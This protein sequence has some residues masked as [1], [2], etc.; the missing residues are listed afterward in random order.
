M[1]SS[2]P[3]NR[4]VRLLERG[5]VAIRNSRF[6]SVSIRSTGSY[7]PA[8]ILTNEEIVG[9]LPTSP[10]WIVQTLG[11]RQRRI[12][13][14]EEYTSDLAA[15]AGLSAIASAGLDPNEI[16]LVIVATSTPDRTVPSSACMAQNKMGIRNGCPA[17]DVAA[18]CSGF[19]YSITIAGQ[20]IQ[21]GVY[22]RALVIGADTYSKVTNWND[23][24]CV[25]FGDGSGAVVLERVDRVNGM[26][27]SILFADG[28][29]MDDFTVLP[30]D[31]YF[32]MNGRAVYEK[33]T[34][35]LP[36]CIRQILCLNSLGLEDVS[37]IIPHQ[38][39]A[40]VLRRTAEILNIP[41][42]RMQTNL[43]FYANT[44]GATIPLL[45]D[46]A[47]RGGLIHKNDLL[48]FAAIGAG[49]TWA[50]TLYRW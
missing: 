48:L 23:R 40:H 21:N 47:N 7:V 45:L 42:S 46:Q 31:G 36:E 17:L 1:R 6:D 29:G 22:D 4:V 44:A 35:A 5:T 9:N 26:F 37:M 3:E 10:E 19:L 41:Y 39:S 27:S 24:N 12:A 8:G 32:R 33:A 28:T 38:A 14:S 43:E 18:V 25:F 20:F 16:D 50:A 11:I 2:K 49:W 13:D 34:A 15:R 30:T